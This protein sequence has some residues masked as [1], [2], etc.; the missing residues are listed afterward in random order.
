MIP[1][2]YHIKIEETEK[3]ENDGSGGA[4]AAGLNDKISSS[5]SANEPEKKILNPQ[6]KK[7]DGETINKALVGDEV[8]ICADTSGISD[9]TSVKIK[10]VE[11]DDDDNDDDVAT[12]SGTV[13]GGK[14]EC[15]WKVIYTA[16]DDD[17]NSQQEMKEKG[18][19]LPEYA[20]IV[21]CDGIVSEESGQLDVMGWIRQKFV[22]K[23]TG[24]PIINEKYKIYLVDG[25][26]I[27]GTTDDDGYVEQTELK[28]G[29]YLIVLGE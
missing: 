21:E 2:F 28:K 15:K 1:G 23:E 18:Y 22:D 12:I 5:S 17:S 26:V 9:G 19:T 20:F 27:N 24:K 25:T 8:L 14:I 16:D 11:K 4:S 10:I 7:S 3:N 13:K 29:K 6:W